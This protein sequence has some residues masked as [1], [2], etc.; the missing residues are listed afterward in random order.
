MRDRKA[1][2]GSVRG[3][4]GRGRGCIVR[5][6][7][8]TQPIDYRH[9]PHSDPVWKAENDAKYAEME[10]VQQLRME[11]ARREHDSTTQFFPAAFPPRLEFS[12]KNIDTKIAATL[13]ANRRNPIMNR[14]IMGASSLQPPIQPATAPVQLPAYPSLTPEDLR[15]YADQLEKGELFP[16]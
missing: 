7:T 13:D 4:R 14:A 2:R 5:P 10:R 16:L 1:A 3:G 15:R 12:G 6:S 11:A 9:L 8:S